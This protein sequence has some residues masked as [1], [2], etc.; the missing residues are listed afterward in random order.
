MKVNNLPTQY[1]NGT[2]YAV[3]L[4]TQDQLQYIVGFGSPVTSIHNARFGIEVIYV[5]SKRV[6]NRN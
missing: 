1:L 6:R 4:A 3:L 5:K 2:K